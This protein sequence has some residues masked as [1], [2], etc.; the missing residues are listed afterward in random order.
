MNNI[1]FFPFFSDNQASFHI[2]LLALYF[3]LFILYNYVTSLEKNKNNLKTSLAES[4]SKF[5][6]NPGWPNNLV[7]YRKKCTQSFF[8]RTEFL[9]TRSWVCQK[10]FEF[11]V[12]ISIHILFIYE[13]RL[14]EMSPFF[15]L[16]N[17]KLSRLDFTNIF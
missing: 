8:R 16:K 6:N 2:V 4:G 10:I 11:S 17:K 3:K 1:T 5:K 9:R 12:Q 13:T 14:W 7:S 15:L